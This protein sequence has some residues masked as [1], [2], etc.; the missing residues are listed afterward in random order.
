MNE[1]WLIELVCV[2]LLGQMSQPWLN[3]CDKCDFSP[4]V[5][6]VGFISGAFQKSSRRCAA[7]SYQRSVLLR[8]SLQLC[9]S[10]LGVR[11]ALSYTC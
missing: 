9:P 7:R 10:F 8:G 4:I 5:K 3:N 6:A 1:P 11:V 2:E